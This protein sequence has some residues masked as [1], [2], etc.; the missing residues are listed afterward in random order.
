MKNLENSLPMG[1]RASFYGCAETGRGSGGQYP[2]LGPLMV[3]GAL[4]DL[5]RYWDDIPA[6]PGPGGGGGPYPECSL[7]DRNLIVFCLASVDGGQIV[8]G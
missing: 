7:F 8:P 5:G 3:N 6:G 2:E 4:P 1:D